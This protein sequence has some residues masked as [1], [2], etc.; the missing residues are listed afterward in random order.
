MCRMILKSGDLVSTWTLIVT[1][2]SSRMKTGSSPS[3]CSSRY[4]SFASAHQTRH[5]GR[6]VVRVQRL[7]RLTGTCRE[8]TFSQFYSSSLDWPQPWTIRTCSL[9]FLR[10]TWTSTVI[11]VPFSVHPGIQN[12]LLIWTGWKNGS[13]TPPILIWTGCSQICQILWNRNHSHLRLPILI[14]LIRRSFCFSWMTSSRAA[15]SCWRTL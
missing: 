6:S 15:L 4:G 1:L 8:P 12:G 9:T 3:L 7:A 13:W 5:G 14:H 11:V 2:T 10:S